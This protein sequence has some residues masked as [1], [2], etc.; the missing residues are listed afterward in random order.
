MIEKDIE[1]ILV[2]E[3]KAA[4]GL[5]YKFISPGNDG[6]PDRIVI[7]PGGDVLFVELKSDKGRLTKLQLRQIERIRETGAEVWVV[8]G[9]SGLAMFFSR[10]GMDAAAQR[11]LE[12][13]AKAYEKR[14]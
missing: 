14:R 7:L 8:Q 4:G 5:A 9:L 2:K 13:V 3:I 12:R 6:V 10:C 1:K 11:A